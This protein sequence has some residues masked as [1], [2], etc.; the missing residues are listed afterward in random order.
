MEKLRESINELF[1]NFK[2]T[3][4]I[5]VD[6]QMD[7]IVEDVNPDIKNCIYKTIREAV[8]NGIKHGNATVFSIEIFKKLRI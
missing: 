3:N 2:E 6:L 4:R 1:E 5:K 7:D 8:T